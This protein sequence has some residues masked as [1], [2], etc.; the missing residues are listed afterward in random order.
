M[1]KVRPIESERFY[2]NFFG[3]FHLNIFENMELKFEKKR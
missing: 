2:D 3:V 1:F